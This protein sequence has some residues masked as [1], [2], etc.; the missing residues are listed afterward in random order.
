MTALLDRLD[1]RY[2]G[3]L[4]R[5]PELGFLLIAVV[6][7]AAAAVHAARFEPAPQRAEPETTAPVPAAPEDA[8]ADGPDAALVG[9]D[10][11]DDPEEYV[12]RRFAELSLLAE[13]HPDVAV[14]AIASFDAYLTPAQAASLLDGLAVEVY[15]TRYRLRAPDATFAEDTQPLARGQVGVVGDVEAALLPA[16]E[17]EAQEARAHAAELERMAATTDDPEFSDTFRQ[18]REALLAAAAAAGPECRCVYAVLLEGTHLEL[19]ELAV[20]A[21][22]RLVDPAPAGTTP[23]GVIFLALAPDP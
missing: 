22:V 16:L 12:E 5:R 2:A 19:A 11:D 17:R 4:R 9:P 3:W 18:D 7:V 23:A 10:P 1:E 15:A 13:D 6:F 20:R 21:G 14:P 8:G